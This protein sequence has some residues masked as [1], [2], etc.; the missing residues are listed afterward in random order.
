MSDIVKC[1][2]KGLGCKGYQPTS[3]EIELTIVNGRDSLASFKYAIFLIWLHEMYKEEPYCCKTICEF[4]EKIYSYSRSSLYRLL[5]EIRINTLLDKDYDFS[6]N[7]IK[8]FICQKL[9]KYLAVCNDEVQSLQYF[10]SFLNTEQDEPI[11]GA[12]VD[13]Y[14]AMYVGTG[15]LVPLSTFI[16][17]GGDL[18]NMKKSL[19]KSTY[20]SFEQKYG[21]DSPMLPISTESE[22]EDDEEDDEEGDEEDDYWDDDE[23]ADT[24]R[25]DEVANSYW[26]D[27]EE[28]DIGGDDEQSINVG[29]AET[30]ELRDS[31]V[32]RAQL[33]MLN[34][35]NSYSPLLAKIAKMIF[36]MNGKELLELQNLIDI[37]IGSYM[38]K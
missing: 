6:D 35:F 34:I 27:D 1:D 7:H 13:I 18:K 36:E 5:N 38:D 23:E 11:T 22:P 29:T 15:T 21:F 16:D 32:E 30:D 2:E 17:N 4:S 10:W 3:E 28:A 14:I 19:A 31:T 26:D 24:G 33:Y 20:S 37:R 12:L 9:A 8:S 25:D